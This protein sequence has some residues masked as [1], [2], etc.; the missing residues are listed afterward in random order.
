M[1]GGGGG[2]KRGEDNGDM[3]PATGPSPSVAKRTEARKDGERQ[4]LRERRGPNTR[5]KLT[6]HE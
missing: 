5:R 4:Q 3:D 2:S 6:Q 1:S